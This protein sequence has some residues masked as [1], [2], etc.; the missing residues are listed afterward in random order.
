[1]RRDSLAHTIYAVFIYSAYPLVFE[2]QE[3]ELMLCAVCPEPLPPALGDG[4]LEGVN[5]LLGPGKQPASDC[6]ITGPFIDL[7]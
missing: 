5:G 1:M 3:H 4:G 7:V 6:F 2:R